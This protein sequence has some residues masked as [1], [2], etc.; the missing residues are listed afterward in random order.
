MSFL[1]GA[2]TVA[3][4]GGTGTGGIEEITGAF[5]GIFDTAQSAGVKI[6][7]GAIA[8]GVIFVVGKWLWGKAKQWLKSV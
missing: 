4:S 1:Q 5:D 2:T 6:V 8:V 3:L 7:L